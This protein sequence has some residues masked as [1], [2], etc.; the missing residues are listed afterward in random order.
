[1]ANRS[2]HSANGRASPSSSDVAVDVLHRAKTP[3]K[4]EVACFASSQPAAT[5]LYAD[6]NDRAGLDPAEK[7]RRATQWMATHA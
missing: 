3:A 1:M 6:E 5:S 2:H 4:V 7:L